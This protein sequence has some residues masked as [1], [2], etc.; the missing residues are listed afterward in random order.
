M[1]ADTG[2]LTRRGLLGAGAAAGA[3]A[4]LPR[5][6]AAA[7]RRRA[8]VVVVGAGLAGLSAAR[9]LAKAGRSV[10][11]LEARD[12]VG[13]R[14]LNRSV[15]GGEVVEVGGQW[16]GPTQDR[17]PA[18]AREVG[19]ETYG[20]YFEG[21]AVYSP[22]RAAAALRR[23]VAGPAGPRRRRGRRAH[24]RAR[25]AERGDP[26]HGALASPRAAE[27]DA[28]RSR[29]TS[30]P[31]SRPTAGASSPT[32]RS[33]RCGRASRATCRCCTSSSTSPA[34]GTRRRPAR[35]CG[36]S[37]PPAAR[38]SRASSAARS[39]SRSA[40]PVAWTTAW[41]WT[42]RS[43]ASSRRAAAS[44]SSRRRHVDVPAVIVAG[45]PALTAQIRFEP[46]LPARPRAAHAA[47]P[48]GQRD[49]VPGRLPPALLAR[50]GPLGLR[51][52]ATAARSG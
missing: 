47:L 12:R 19:V 24:R 20:T 6:A 28:R 10:A 18:L 50:G 46:A 32:W 5:E 35:S 31:T 9:V 44:A 17:L 16:I 48:A 22:A 36:S 33:R 4:A 37:P 43:A 45:P 3:A 1:S 41:C 14:I 26:A 23:R 27:F 2:R 7:R 42:P 52:R 34:R 38:R 11:V 15:G 13:G 40:W 51:Q 39:A 8:D 21:Q 49:Q 29:P 30:S 25:P